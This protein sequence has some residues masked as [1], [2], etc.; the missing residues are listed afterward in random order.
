MFMQS[1]LLVKWRSDSKYYF[2]LEAALK[3]PRTSHDGKAKINFRHLQMAFV[4]LVVGSALSFLVFVV[5]RIQ[6][7]RDV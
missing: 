7:Q 4:G 5:E 2:K 3:H 1:G 6:A